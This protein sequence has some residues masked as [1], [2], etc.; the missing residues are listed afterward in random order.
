M[1]R[2]L[3][4]FSVLTV[5]AVAAVAA[6][7][8]A[9]AVPQWRPSTTEMPAMPTAGDLQG[10]WMAGLGAWFV[11]MD[12]VTGTSAQGLRAAGTPRP[13]SSRS[14]VARFLRGP[15]PVVVMTDRNADD[16]AD[17]IEYFRNGTLVVQV[18]DADYNGRANAIRFYDESGALV[19]EERL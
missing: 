19:R 16:R 15:V 17:M 6:D 5:L 9:Q 10:N 18:I 8:N 4:L 1:Y 3:R 7:A 13:G 12:Q 14:Q 2:L 11:G